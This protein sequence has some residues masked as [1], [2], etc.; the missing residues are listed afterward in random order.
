[1]READLL[2][3]PLRLPV[4]ILRNTGRFKVQKSA[5]QEFGGD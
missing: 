4:R 3:E 5:F 2:P 1:M